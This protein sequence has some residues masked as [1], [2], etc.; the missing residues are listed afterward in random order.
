L[1]NINAPVKRNWS[2]CFKHIKREANTVADLLAKA[3]AAGTSKW[4]EM[5]EPPPVAIPF[6]QVDAARVLYLRS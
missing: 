4:T 6:L 5:R 1:A 3:G 2:T